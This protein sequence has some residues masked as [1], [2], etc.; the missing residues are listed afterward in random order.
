M[1]SAR[2]HAF[3]QIQH[4]GPERLGILEQEGDGSFAR[5]AL[6]E[7]QEARA[8]VVDERG[9]VAPRFVESQQRLETIHRPGVR[10][11]RAHALDEFPQALHGNVGRVVVADA[12]DLPHDRR[13]GG[14]RG[15]VGAEVAAP[16]QHDA[17][18]VQPSQEFRREPGLADP[19]LADHGE[20]ERSR[21]ADHA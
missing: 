19:R 16:D 6:D 17:L 7:G 4:L 21:R 5:E 10:P 12:G 3:D 8:N 1:P 9:F 20:Q 14:E 11:R 15:A 18:G 2:R 13:S